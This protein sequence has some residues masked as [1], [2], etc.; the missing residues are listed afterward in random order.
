MAGGT[1]AFVS[2]DIS[3]RQARSITAGQ[4]LGG[5]H[6]GV[7]GATEIPGGQQRRRGGQGRRWARGRCWRQQ[8]RP[9]T[10]GE[11]PAKRATAKQQ[12]W[13]L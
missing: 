11:T 9:L 8:R 13:T 3:G 6:C 1:A 2:E 7:R 5:A 10:G 12:F 4:H